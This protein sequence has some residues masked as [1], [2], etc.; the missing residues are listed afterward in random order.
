M[1]NTAGQQV[2]ELIN[3]N[4]EPSYYGVLFRAGHLASGVYYA[5]LIATDG[6]QRVLFQET[7][8]LLL[9]K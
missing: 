9:E 8:K 3:E 4:Q 7:M 1:Y 5:R 2:A 6:M